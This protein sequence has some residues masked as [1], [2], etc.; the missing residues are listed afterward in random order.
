MGK[1]LLVCLQ[2]E[3]I[4]PFRKTN[5]L[6][7]RCYSI[8][9]FFDIFIFQGAYFYN[10]IKPDDTYFMTKYSDRGEWYHKNS[11]DIQVKVF[12]VEK[13]HMKWKC[14]VWRE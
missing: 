1:H 11:M 6:F 4:S 8:F 5:K 13:Y 3:K 9:L 7:Y 12:W 14:S 10:D 2:L